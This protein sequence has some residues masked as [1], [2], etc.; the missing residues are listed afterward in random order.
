MGEQEPGVSLFGKDNP[1]W[2][3]GR[4]I[5]QHGYVLINVGKDH[6][7]A[8]CRGYAYEHRLR[9]WEAGHNVTGKHVHH[10]TENR[11]DNDPERLTPLTP[12]WHRFKHRKIG[13]KLR[14][15]DE[16]NQ[17]VICSCGCGIA[18]QKYDLNG[19]P[20]QYISGHNTKLTVKRTTQ[21]SLTNFAKG[22]P[23]FTTS[24]AINASGLTKTA[25][26]V[27][28]SKLGK[29]GVLEHLGYGEWRLNAKTEG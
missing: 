10:E 2:K 22:K 8:D 19:R 25:V 3:G 21:D 16:S 6:P 14:L 27:C 5:T 15:P 1:N 12:A 24:E 23:S 20:R 28:L 7:L 13:S 4:T 18:L 9:A 29:R 26:K 17:T 11:Q